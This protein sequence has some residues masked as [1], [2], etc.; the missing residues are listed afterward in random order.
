MMGEDLLL[1][2]NMT[3]VRVIIDSALVDQA[4]THLQSIVIKQYMSLVPVCG[5]M[6][7]KITSFFL[8]LERCKHGTVALNK[9]YYGIVWV[10]VG[11][12]WH[13]ICRRS[14][15]TNADASVICKQLGFS[16]Y[17]I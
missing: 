10:C 17:G 11:G 5:E 3:V 8:P 12:I 1:I 16:P 14:H 15:W 9:H 2:L 13:N 6:Q 7:Q 4:L